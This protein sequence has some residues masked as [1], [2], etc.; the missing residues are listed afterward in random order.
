M[1]S[2]KPLGNC[3]SECSDF[4]L[5]ILFAIS[6]MSSFISILANELKGE[7]YNRNFDIICFVFPLIDLTIIIIDLRIPHSSCYKNLNEKEKEL[8]SK[9]KYFIDSFIAEL[10]LYP[11]T[12]C[13]VISTASGRIW[14]KDLDTALNNSDV[15]FVST[16]KLNFKILLLFKFRNLLIILQEK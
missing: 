13:S 7:G 14:E 4:L 11:V 3:P 9:R 5:Y 1:L 12:V 10:L 6:F 15:F 16:F 2:D 8:F